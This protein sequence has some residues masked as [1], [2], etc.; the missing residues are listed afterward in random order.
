MAARRP[1]DLALYLRLLREARPHWGLI[2][3]LFLLSL[4]ATPIALL[5]PLPLKI[6]I[7]SVFSSEPV[8]AALQR[9]LPAGLLGSPNTL[10]AVA[11]VAVLVFAL[12]DHLQR[13][14]VS[15]LGTYAG[16]RLALEFRAKIFRHVQRV[17]VS[18]HDTKGAAD[19]AYRIHWDAASIQWVMLYGVTPFVS[20][21]MTLAGMLYVTAVLDRQLALVALAVAPPV[22]LITSVARRRLRAGWATAKELESR[23]VAVVQEAL[24]GLRV[25]K[26]FGQEDREQARFVSSLGQR[27]RAWIS[28]AL[29]EG[30]FELLTGLTIAAGTAVVLYLGAR[31]VRAG[32]LS[33]GDLVLV[34]SYLARLYLPFQEI[35]KSINML[36]SAIASAERAFGLLDEP[37]DVIEKSVA[38]RL[39]RA[40]GAITFRNVS[41]TYGDQHDLILHNVSFDI[42]PG[43]RVGITGTTGAGKTTLVS[44]LMRFYDPTS[45]DIVLD[46]V[47]LR[48]YRLADLRNQFGVALQDPVLFSA[49]V[50]ENIAY[51]RPEAS[52]EEI[53]AA[54]KAANAHEFITALPDGYRTVVGE[55]G[56]RLSGGERQR[57]AL[58]R[59]FLKDAPILI[60]DEPTSSVDLKTELAIMD[61]ME[62]LM[63]GRTTLMIAHRLSTLSQF[64][65]RLALEN[66]RSSAWTATVRD[67]E[68]E[69][70]VPRHSEGAAGRNG[71]R[72]GRG[73]QPA[74]T[75]EKRQ[76]AR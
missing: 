36:Q 10:L 28:L 8:P 70:P 48:D 52:E 13:L 21:A 49:S 56:M 75:V 9:L 30:A 18:Y 14:S 58:A 24:S 39:S 27:M 40:K 15:I 11:A 61:A 25:V 26:A 57:V 42:E 31:H 3:L 51:A 4:L 74:K 59:A 43:S 65:L 73:S 66:G 6:A 12:V 69:P 60:L 37:T 22:F 62:R 45:G 76:N 50:A 34:M 63:R 33:V 68:R 53:V 5:L 23:A 38:R 1:N 71:D 64:D 47:D 41:F 7:D 17:S 54:A 55:R 46:G 2:V 35:S 16:E 72:V 32:M 67:A 29:A 19:S 20:A 44:L